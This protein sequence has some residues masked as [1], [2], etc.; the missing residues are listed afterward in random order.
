MPV[1]FL[2][3][4]LPPNAK[5]LSLKNMPAEDGHSGGMPLRLAHL[6]EEAESPALSLPANVSLTA[7][8]SVRH[9]IAQGYGCC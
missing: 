2:A 8:F 9:G 5:L 4:A 6:Y 7:V 1:S 3:Q